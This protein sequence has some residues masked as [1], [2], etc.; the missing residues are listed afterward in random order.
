M[1]YLRQKLVLAALFLAAILFFS[2]F[3][4]SYALENSKLLRVT[5]LDV[6]QG[7]CI[8]IRT[9]SGKVIMIDAGD[10]TKYAAE[11]YIL[12]YLEAND[13]KKI[14]MFIITHAHRDHIGG[15]LKLIP[16][17]EIGAV[18]ESKPSVT[19]IYAEI[20]SMLKKRKV[21]VYK[22]W[23]GDKLDFGDGIDAAI[24][25]PSRE[26]YGLQGESIDMS[27]QDGDVS[28]TEGE[29]NLNNFSVTL[30]LQ[31]KD[32][33]YHFPGDSEKQAE[34]HMLKVNPEN[35]FPS[36]VYKV[37]HHGSKTSSDPGYLNKLKPALSVISCGVNNKFKHPS[38]ST[39]QNLQYYSKN[40]LRTDEDKTVETWTDGVEFNYSSNSTP[41][42]IVSGPVVS[43][44]TPYSAT[45]EWETTHLS[46]TKV[47]YSAAGAG[48]AAS[49][50]SSDNQ[51]D[52]QLTLT[53]L[54]PNTTYN[55]EIESVAVKDASQ[56]LSA[57]GTFKTSEESASGVKITSMNM[58]P[59]TSLIYEPV[60][61][62]VKVEGAPEKSKVTFYEDSVVEKNKAGECKL[63]SG[64]IAKF[65]WTP[66]QSKQYELLFVVSD[67]EKVLAIGSMRAMVT[68]RLVLCDL[69]HGN[70]NA[71]KYESFKVDLYSRGFEVGD[72]N[73][74]ITANTLKNAA[75]LVMSEFAT[76][77]AGLN[78]AELGVIKKFVDNGGGL[79][80]LSRADF[81]NYS[82]PQT[83]NKVLE[84]IGSNIRFNDDEVMD[85]TNSPGQNMAYLLFMHQFEKSIISPDVK[86]MI[87]KGS[88]S[89]LNAK[90]K[91]ITAADKTIIP[92]TYGDDDTYTIDSDNAGDGVVY[93]AG[94][95]VVVDAG[96]I[97]PGGGKVATFGGFHIDSGAYTYSANN[98]THV[99]NFDVVNWLARP[100]KQ[101][102]DELSAEMSYISDDTRNSAAEGEVNQSAV[103]S[104]S[105]RADKISKELLEEFDY[106]ADKIEASIDHFVGFFNGGNAK[107]ISSF[108]GVIKKVLDRVR[109]EAAENSELMQ[110][111]GDKI[112]ALEDLYHR[113]LKLNK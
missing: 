63:T 73:E 103:I 8:I 90:M 66:Q 9:P 108:S 109:Y 68:R 85:P 86:M 69:A 98:Q 83:L 78:A 16:K 94:S 13:I 37:A 58:S 53:G 104:T 1:K 43:G 59:K 56:I 64:G 22:A 15:M 32:I 46:T 88:S 87:V 41:N 61:L 113:S 105:I 42:A 40:T 25:H 17:V 12:P 55:F 2:G 44:I 4:V 99:Y 5:F 14:D 107:Y 21:P 57:Q 62:V 26:W 51:L 97:L 102:V 54:T 67:G 101:R 20:M 77:E 89:M 106:S 34:E 82:Q 7:D 33:I 18:Y 91:L 72:I 27:T 112:K 92:I 45:I 75:V 30:R 111:S 35:L 60:K 36:T 79:L 65:D 24:L 11:K 96:E 48:S 19:Q 81:G 28:A 10:D 23:K 31:Y 49:K 3:E 84:Q 76:T 6:D 39:V 110:K 95:K 50:Q 38:P 70:Y 80:L 71:A 93:P 52:H 100:A 29:E 74:R 47:K